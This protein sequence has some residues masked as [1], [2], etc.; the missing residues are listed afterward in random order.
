RPAARLRGGPLEEESPGEPPSGRGLG[1]RGGT[2]RGE[3]VVHDGGGRRLPGP[4]RVG[5]GLRLPGSR[6]A[7]GGPRQGKGRGGRDRED[8]YGVRGEPGGQVP[9]R[10]SRGGDAREGPLAAPG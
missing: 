10:S 7:A 9:R 2:R 6:R 3:R 1:G 4:A 8:V 5:P